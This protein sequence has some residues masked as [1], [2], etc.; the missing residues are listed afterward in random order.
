MMLARPQL[1]S[2]FVGSSEAADTRSVQRMQGAI[3]PACD[4][5]MWRSV[6]PLRE[7]SAFRHALDPVRFRVR[8]LAVCDSMS[9]LRVGCVTLFRHPSFL[10]R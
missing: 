3:Q 6:P 1:E 5:G 8:P 4:L 9:D 2:G 10:N 7:D